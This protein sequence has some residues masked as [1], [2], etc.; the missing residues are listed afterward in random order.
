MNMNDTNRNTI[1]GF[2]TWLK[3][4][5]YCNK[6]KQKDLA[7]KL[8]T[9]ETSVSR[10]VNGSRSPSAQQLETILKLFNSHIEIVPNT[11]IESIHL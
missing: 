11:Q 4:T 2:G 3:V 5:L 8:G 1:F 9:T 6:M 7:E 10:W